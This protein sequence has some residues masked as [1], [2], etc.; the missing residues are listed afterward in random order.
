MPCADSSGFVVQLNAETTH[1]KDVR[2]FMLHDVTVFWQDCTEN[3]MAIIE[4]LLSSEPMVSMAGG[5]ARCNICVP[6]CNL[7]VW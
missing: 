2:V 7:G 1:F 5:I 4:I 6:Y 3:L